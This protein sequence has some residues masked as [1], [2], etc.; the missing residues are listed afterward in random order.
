VAVT[1]DGAGQLQATRSLGEPI[2]W[3]DIDTPVEQD[4]ETGDYTTHVPRPDGNLF[5]RVLG[6]DGTVE[7]SECGG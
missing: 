3:T 2:A 1:W 4:P 5:F 7:C 6:P